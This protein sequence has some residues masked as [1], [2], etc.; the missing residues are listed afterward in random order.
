MRPTSIVMLHLDRMSVQWG[1]NHQRQTTVALSVRQTSQ[2]HGSTSTCCLLSLDNRLESRIETSLLFLRHLI[3]L[4]L[5]LF[6]REVDSVQWFILQR[7]GYQGLTASGNMD[8]WGSGR[9]SR[10]ESLAIHANRL[11]GH[12]AETFPNDAYDVRESS[13]E[14]LKRPEPF[15]VM[16]FCRDHPNLDQKKR[17]LD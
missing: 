10:D 12:I 14:E 11:S 15:H 16:S 1:A 7:D 6:A 3:E 9:P 4:H 17:N 2:D 13:D 8:F 5:I